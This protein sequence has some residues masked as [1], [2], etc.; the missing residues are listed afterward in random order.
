MTLCLNNSSS[1]SRL[2]MLFP[3][4]LR[5]IF[6]YDGTCKE[7]FSKDVIPDIWK[8]SWLNWHANLTCPYK[9]LVA[10]WLLTTWNVYDNPM[11]GS[12]TYELFRKHYHTSDIVVMTRFVDTVNNDD[13]F[14]AFTDDSEEILGEEDNYK[15][16]VQVY[17]MHPG[18]TSVIFAGEIL[19][20][21]QYVADCQQENH[22]F[23]NNILIHSNSDTGLCLY[24]HLVST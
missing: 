7:I 20:Q 6:E 18:S 10:D 3:D 15:C 9:H 1:R 5:H 21:T 17:M 19:T 23:E 4:L 8:T 2:S 12:G 13:N 14:F 22:Y 11:F 24:Q 16:M